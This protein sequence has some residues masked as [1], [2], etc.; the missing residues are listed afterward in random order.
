MLSN[1]T[2]GADIKTKWVFFYISRSVVVTRFFTEAELDRKRDDFKKAGK[3]VAVVTPF[4][5]Q[6]VSKKAVFTL[7]DRKDTI[8]DLIINLSGGEDLDETSCMIKLENELYLRLD[9]DYSLCHL[10]RFWWSTSQKK[11]LPHKRGTCEI[12][13]I[14]IA[15]LPRTFW[16][17]VTVK[18]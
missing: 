3:S 5:S 1:R 8:I 2:G 17:G 13:I 15:G 6:Q 12:T 14:I 10:R 7:L 4:A 16:T 18:L 9:A 11:L